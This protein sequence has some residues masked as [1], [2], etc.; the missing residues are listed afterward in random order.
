MLN[1]FTSFH[2]VHP[3]AGASLAIALFAAGCK[4]STP[5]ESPASSPAAQPA[6][7]TQIG[8]SDVVKLQRK[9]TG[10]GS[11]PE[12]LTAT[13]LP[14]RGMNLYQ[15]TANIPGKGEIPLFFDLPDQFNSSNDDA[16]GDA[17]FLGGGAFLAPYPNRIR[18]KISPDGKTLT[19]EWHGKTLTL[20][21]NW[22]GKKD[23]AEPHAIHGLILK[24]QAESLNTETTADGQTESGVIHAGDFGGRW[25]SKTDLTFTIALT[26]GAIDTTITAKNVGDEPEPMSIGWHPY[27]AIPSG[28]RTQARLHVPAEKLALV[29]NYDDV[30]PTGKLVPVKS[31]EGGK[32]D[33]NAPNGKPLD[34]DFLDDNFSTL[35][36]TAGNV[37]VQLTDPAAAYGI[38][39]LGVS[40]EIKTVQVYAPPAK[41]FTAIEEQFNFGDPFGKEWH[42]MDTGMVTLKPGDSVTWHTRLVLFTPAK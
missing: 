11:K 18:G 9:A 14:G 29:N 39:I 34:G 35:K 24:S 1:R 4:S 7:A 2:R 15:I 25:L 8:G 19:T 3:I 36:R 32:Y 12:F 22:K 31:Y 41:Q 42:G 28:D 23:G 27:F 17:S 38:H 16:N 13:I 30:F 5:A 37:D 20:P 40:P 33:Y 26:G 21:A 6:A 10:D